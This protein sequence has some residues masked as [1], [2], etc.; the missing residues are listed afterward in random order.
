MGAPELPGALE[1][2]MSLGSGY[3]VL[4]RKES[5]GD[6]KERGGGRKERI[7]KEKTSQIYGDRRTLDLVYYSTVC[8]KLM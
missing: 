4:G 2:V 6:R 3:G 5:S 8:L 7:K 1:T